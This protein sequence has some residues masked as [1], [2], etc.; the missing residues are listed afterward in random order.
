MEALQLECNLAL[1]EENL[2]LAQEY[3]ELKNYFEDKL[4]ETQE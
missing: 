3:A 4:K 2:E 1:Y